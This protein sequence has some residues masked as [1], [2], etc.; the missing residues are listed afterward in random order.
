MQLALESIPISDLKTGPNEVVK[1]IAQRPMML[2]QNGRSIAVLVSPEDW[3]RREEQLAERRFTEAEVRAIAEAYRKEAE[4]SPTV[5]LEGH[6]ARMAERHGH[7][8]DQV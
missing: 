6:K 8:A 5:T 1:K 3:N 2:T 4:D 7:V